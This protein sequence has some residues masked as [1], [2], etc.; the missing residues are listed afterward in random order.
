[1]LLLQLHAAVCTACGTTQQG[2]D[3]RDTT[4]ECQLTCLDR[5]A[6]RR[7]E[8]L[9]PPPALRAAAGPSSLSSH[10]PLLRLAMPQQ[11]IDSGC[12]CM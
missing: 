10:L 9:Q 6:S 8:I 11:E 2:K 4:I 3:S 5:L 7:L 1:M 12:Y